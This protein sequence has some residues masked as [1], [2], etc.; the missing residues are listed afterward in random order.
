MMEQELASVKKKIAKFESMARDSALRRINSP[1]E[2]RVSREIRRLE[3]SCSKSLQK[4]N[5][6]QEE[7]TLC[8]DRACRLDVQLLSCQQKMTDLESALQSLKEKNMALQQNLLTVEEKNAAVKLAIESIQQRTQCLDEGEA[9]L[10]AVIIEYVSRNRILRSEEESLR[11]EICKLRSHINKLI[12]DKTELS[13]ASG[14]KKYEEESYCEYQ[15]GLISD[16]ENHYMYNS[17]QDGAG[18]LSL[19]EAK[20]IDENRN[21]VQDCENHEETPTQNTIELYGNELLG[22]TKKNTEKD[23]HECGNSLQVFNG[24]RSFSDRG[25]HRETAQDKTK[26]SSEL[27]ETKTNVRRLE[28]ENASTFQMFD[29]SVI[30]HK[31]ENFKAVESQEKPELSSELERKKGVQKRET[32][33]RGKHEETVLDKTELS[34]ELSQTKKNVRKPEQKNPNTVRVFNTSGN[35]TDRGKHDETVLDK[36]EL[37]SELSETKNG[38]EK[39]EQESPGTLR[40]FNT[41]ITDCEKHE[42]TA[43][44]KPKSWIELSQTDKDVE[45]RDQETAYTP[46]L[47]CTLRRFSY[48]EKLEEAAQCKTDLS[49]ELSETKKDVEKREQESAS[50]LRVFNTDLQKHEETVQGKTELSGGLSETN[51]NVEKG[52]EQENASPVR[53]FDENRSKIGRNSIENREETTQRHRLFFES[54]SENSGAE[55]TRKFQGFAADLET[56][57]ATCRRAEDSLEGD[58]IKL[59]AK[60]STLESHINKLIQE[61]TELLA[62]LIK[63]KENAENGDQRNTNTLHYNFNTSRSFPETQNEN[64]GEEIRKD[65]SSIMSRCLGNNPEIDPTNDLETNFF[66]CKSEDKPLEG[67]LAKLRASWISALET[68]I[69]R[70]I[71]D[72]VGLLDSFTD[73]ENSDERI[74]KDLFSFGAPDEKLGDEIRE[75]RELA[76]D[77]Q[78]KYTT[79]KTEL[80]KQQPREEAATRAKRECA[81][82]LQ[83]K[84]DESRLEVEK[85][86]VMIKTLAEDK[87][88]LESNIQE[89]VLHV[90]LKCDSCDAVL[91]EIRALCATFTIGTRES[92]PKL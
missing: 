44:D 38:V 76:S 19:I 63:I 39:R 84:L 72:K 32:T 52:A 75:F 92:K 85:R 60:I 10:R 49:S 41:A 55:E 22:E 33:D 11:A 6:L 26:F 57:C 30:F 83:L 21:P 13:E 1:A 91:D 18:G 86:D 47:A 87:R 7:I 37:S 48:C 64:F 46:P 73:V 70:L 27:K 20:K 90:R 82:E 66:A 69:Y 59:R 65:L 23:N 5:R 12:Q 34:S 25:K 42:N 43:E 24:S 56:K 14:R 68:H 77:L 51:K 53:D 88:R 36:T 29:T 28:Q 45:E 16:S 35:F 2:F 81:R 54:H 71:V 50:D 67:E 8:S 78:T 15:N 62:E 61:K 80:E 74:E 31:S 89:F 58:L 17:C 4:E 3:I 79:C 40:V 9:Q